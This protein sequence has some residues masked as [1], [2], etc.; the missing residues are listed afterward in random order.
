M[1]NSCPWSY[2]VISFNVRAQSLA[3]HDQPSLCTL[4]YIYIHISLFVFYISAFCMTSA[5]LCWPLPRLRR[6]SRVREIL[7]GQ[8]G[9][10]WMSCYLNQTLKNSWGSNFNDRS[11]LGLSKC[12]NQFAWQTEQ[13]EGYPSAG[14][15]IEGWGQGAGTWPDRLGRWKVSVS[16]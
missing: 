9:L 8:S 7:S 12:C 10:N 3:E 1:S 6:I 11:L 14:P 5:R 13:W 4:Q 16:K 2:C 15:L